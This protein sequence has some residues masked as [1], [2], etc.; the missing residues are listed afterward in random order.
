MSGQIIKRG[1]SARLVRIF[2]GRDPETGKRKYFSHVVH[3][4]KKEA[5][6][7]LNNTLR[8]RDMGRFQEPSRVTLGEYMKQWLQNAAAPKLREA[9]PVRLRGHHP[10]VHSRP[11]RP[12]SPAAAHAAGHSEPACGTPRVWPVGADNPED[13]RRLVVGAR[14][15]GTL[16]NA[17]VQP[18]AECRTAAQQHRSPRP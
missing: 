15:G 12:H 1:D 13:A 2:L 5:L 14:P 7:Y 3:G 8:E 11:P 4:T 6:A 17:R 18:G 16:G 9:N 10:S